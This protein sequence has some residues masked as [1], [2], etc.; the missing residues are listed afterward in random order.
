MVEEAGLPRFRLIDEPSAAALGY[1]VFLEP[2][3]VYLIFDFGGGTLDVAV[4]VIEDPT[5]THGQRCRVLG[6]AGAEIGGASI[7]QWLFQDALHQAGRSDSEDEIRQ[8]S[9]APC[10]RASVPKNGFPFRM[11][12]TSKCPW[13]AVTHLKRCLAAPI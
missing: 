8:A 11:K 13:R 5:K 10:R 3:D 9:R 1:G 4:I 7:D 6:K 2:G 12:A